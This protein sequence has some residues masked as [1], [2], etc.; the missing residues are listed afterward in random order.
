MRPQKVEAIRSLGYG[1]SA[2]VI[3]QFKSPF[4]KTNPG[5]NV[6]ASA[7]NLFTDFPSFQMAWDMGRMQNGDPGI[8]TFF[9]GGAHAAKPKPNRIDELLK[10]LAQ[11]YPNAKEEYIQGRK[12]EYYWASSPYHLGGYTCPKPGQFT[13][14]RGVE[15]KP[16]CGMRLFFVG[17]HCESDFGFLNSALVSASNSAEWIAASRKL[18]RRR[19]NSQLS[20]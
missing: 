18:T 1:N 9:L 6:P 3:A 7:G 2:K 20:S 13:A 19:I 5:N 17:E 8:L 11:I 4:W 12:W 14:I 10:S 15:G 16:E